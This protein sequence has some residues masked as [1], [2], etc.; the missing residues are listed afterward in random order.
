MA[1]MPVLTTILLAPLVGAL[2]LAFIPKE[3]E[4]TLKNVAALA[5]G[6]SFSLS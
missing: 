4:K 3:A 1:G 6:V 2:V 5:M